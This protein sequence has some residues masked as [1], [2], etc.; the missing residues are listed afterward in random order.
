KPAA[1]R[2]SNL[3]VAHA[4][5]VGKSGCQERLNGAA[6][7]ACGA[8]KFEHQGPIELIDL[9]ARWLN[10]CVC[11]IHRHMDAGRLT[12]CW[13]ARISRRLIKPARSGNRSFGFQRFSMVLGGCD[14]W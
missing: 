5:M 1:T 10:R 9:C 12:Q 13:A 11:L 2:I 8:A 6:V 14:V 3:D 4:R 7:S